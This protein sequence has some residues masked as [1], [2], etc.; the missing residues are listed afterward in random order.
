MAM[1]LPQQIRRASVHQRLVIAHISPDS[2]CAGQ[3]TVI[4]ARGVDF[5]AQT[6]FYARPLLTDVDGS[7]ETISAMTKSWKT[8][9]IMLPTWRGDF[10]AFCL[11]DTYALSTGT[12]LIT[13]SNAVPEAALSN[14]PC[15]QL[16]SLEAS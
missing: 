3:L 16:C 6:R 7:P 1:L 2:L 10:S 13:A 14:A 5:S 9:R 15:V 12:Y 4:R 8:C 11:F